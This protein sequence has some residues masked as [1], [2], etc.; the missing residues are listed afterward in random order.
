M[1]LAAISLLIGLFVLVRAGDV[2]V[3]GAAQLARS[4]KMSSVVIGAIVLGFGTSAPELVVS[5][6]AALR[7]NA[8]LGVGNIV[9]SNV[10]NLSLVLGVAA[11]VTPIALSSSVI[12][13]QAPLSIAAVIA[14][15]AA[16][17]D[18]RLSRSDGTILL[19]LLVAAMIILVKTPEE[20]SP[21][22]VGVQKP[23]SRSLLWSLLGLGGVLV[24][25]QLAVS[26]ATKLA[27]S[28]GLSGGFIGFS[29]VA[30]GT[31][32]PELVTAV[33]AARKKEAGLIVGN[34]FGSNLFN[35]LAG[36]AAMGL[37]GA[38]Q[39]GDAKL[40]SGALIAMLGAVI[41]AYARGA[42]KRRIGKSDAIMLLAI[43]AGAMVY[44]AVG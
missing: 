34:L 10:A 8:A 13:R 20:G 16:V 24:G 37:A 41:W 31:S 33:A 6:I 29:L 14:F 1:L 42:L 21:T 15:A 22:D 40:T 4:L 9:G 32:L 11:L 3:E 38:G 7:G 5:T 44:L 18:G 27:E 36:G 39:I 43:Y 19:V 28:W 25:A 2:F 30:L 26:G 17:S 35:G 12:R 23:V